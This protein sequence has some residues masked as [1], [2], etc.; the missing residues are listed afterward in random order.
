[1]KTTLTI[2]P[3]P[4]N[5]RVLGEFFD[6]MKKLGIDLQYQSLDKIIV[7]TKDQS[8]VER[9]LVIH[10]YR[11]SNENPL[12]GALNKLSEKYQLKEQSL[13]LVGNT[14]PNGDSV[15][16]RNQ[17][18]SSFQQRLTR[19]VQGKARS[20]RQSRNKRRA[21]WARDNLDG[22]VSAYDE[23]LRYLKKH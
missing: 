9:V 3:K 18:D 4:K 11:V 7:E 17:K 15:R 20:A 1:M 12:Q 8:K 19:F 10:G 2:H 22:K 21:Q 13:S 16:E 6:N 23:I 14:E 5:R